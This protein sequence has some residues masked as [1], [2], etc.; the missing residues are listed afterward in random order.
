MDSIKKTIKDYEKLAKENGFSL[1]PNEK[2]V[3]F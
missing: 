3:N 1:N 2:V